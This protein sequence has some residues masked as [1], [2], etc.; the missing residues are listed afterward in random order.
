[1]SFKQFIEADFG[2]LRKQHDNLIKAIVQAVYSQI[3]NLPAQHFYTKAKNIGADAITK[4]IIKQNANIIGRAAVAV[5][6]VEEKLRWHPARWFPYGVTARRHPDLGV[7]LPEMV[8]QKL[9]YIK[10]HPE[11]ILKYK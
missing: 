10:R 6:D 5:Q 8:A 2:V 3:P 11:E 9:E 4:L 7:V 1:M